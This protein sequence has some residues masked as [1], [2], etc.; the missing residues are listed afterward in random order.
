MQIKSA[1]NMG[2]EDRFPYSVILSSPPYVS[3]VGTRRGTLLSQGY[4]SGVLADF[5]PSREICPPASYRRI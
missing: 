5:D 1:Q 3:P 4:P 2:G